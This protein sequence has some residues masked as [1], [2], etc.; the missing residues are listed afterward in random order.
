MYLI[1][2]VPLLR[3]MFWLKYQ[4]TQYMNITLYNISY[5][6]IATAIYKTK[7]YNSSLIKHAYSY[8]KMQVWK[9]TLVSI[10]YTFSF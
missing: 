2:L 6:L 3:Y 8:K 1:K 10:M 4:Q 9:K 5:I 7:Y